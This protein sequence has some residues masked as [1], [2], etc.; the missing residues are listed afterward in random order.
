MSVKIKVYNAIL[1]VLFLSNCRH[2][3]LNKKVAAIFKSTKKDFKKLVRYEVKLCWHFHCRYCTV[4][5]C[6]V[7]KHKQLPSSWLNK[8]A[9]SH[10]DKAFL[11]TFYFY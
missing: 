6:T 1:N 9:A 8:G 4:L 2:R 5:Y 11:K 7:L 3:C 10:K